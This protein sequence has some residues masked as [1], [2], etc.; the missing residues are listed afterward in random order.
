MLSRPAGSSAQ[1]RKSKQAGN[2]SAYPRLGRTIPRSNAGTGA[3]SLPAR[4]NPA[5]W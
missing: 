3:T 4:W 5:C 1:R 2:A